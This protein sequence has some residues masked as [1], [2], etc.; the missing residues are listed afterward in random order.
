M[1]KETKI[2]ERKKERIKSHKRH[3]YRSYEKKT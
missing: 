3:G 1:T 2:R